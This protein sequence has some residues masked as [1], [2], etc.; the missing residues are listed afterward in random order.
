M[1]DWAGACAAAGFRVIAQRAKRPLLQAWPGRATADETTLREWWAKRPYADIGLVTGERA[2]VFDIEGPYLDAVLSQGAVPRTPVVATPSGA[3]MSTSPRSGSGTA[4]SSSTKRLATGVVLEHR[5]ATAADA[6]LP[7][8]RLGISERYYYKLL[9]RHRVP[10]ISGRYQVDS[11]VL[12]ALRADLDQRERPSP[13]RLA[14]ELLGRGFGKAAARKWL[15]RHCFEAAL[16][17][18]PRIRG[19]LP[20]EQGVAVAASENGEA[21]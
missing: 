10:K 12:D 11:G 2:D 14:M 19:P 1:I 3:A 13:R 7:W 6:S 8:Q 4:G 16:K 9:R 20:G 5:K 17:A 18:W 15:E 21:D